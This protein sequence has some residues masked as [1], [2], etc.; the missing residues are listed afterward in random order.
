MVME[1]DMTWGGKHT[2]Q[3]MAIY[4]MYYRVVPIKPI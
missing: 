3:Y 1:K 2:V 4:M